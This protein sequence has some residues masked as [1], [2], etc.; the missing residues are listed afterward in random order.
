MNTN[1]YFNQLSL[2]KKRIV[3]A[4]RH[5]ANTHLNHTPRFKYFTLHGSTHIDN[6]LNLLNLLYEAGLRLDQE[7]SFYLLCAI[8]C[9]DIGMVIPLV[10][11]D[12]T[13]IFQGQEQ[14]ADPAHIEK[15]IRDTHHELVSNYLNSHSDFLAESGLSSPQCTL[16]KKIAMGHRV[17]DLSE[18]PGL[19][20]TLG[21]LLRV[22]DELDIGPSRAPT[23]I[24]RSQY[25]EWDPTSCWHWFKHNITAEWVKGHTVNIEL[26]GIPK[27]TF[28]IA[29]FPPSKTSID[30]WLHQIRRPIYK[31]LF[32]ENCHRIIQDQWGIDIAFE[33]SKQLSDI[34]QSDECWR[35]IEEK[36][37]AGQRQTILLIDDEVRK[38][39]DLM[40]PLQRDYHIIFAPTLHDAVLK[41]QATS[42]DLAIIDMQMGS[43]GIFTP[44]QTDNYKKTGAAIANM[45]RNKWPNTNI[46]ILTGSKH[47]LPDIESRNDLSFFMKKPVNP[48]T[49]E[50]EVRRVLYQQ[51]TR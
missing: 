25:H 6:L 21:A 37:L 23:T 30:Y 49:F 13:S 26:G 27:I 51:K 18:E 44:E 22:L 11:F 16:I 31:V 24:L 9:H 46:G 40:L 45:I 48:E 14:P 28:N 41:L 19:Q 15:L 10:E 39:E 2:E 36:A 12:N 20:K 17:V 4:L 35:R 34:G 32:D 43:S 50:K 7:E 5:S 1:A 47:P 3:E 8:C 33:A 29:V 38:M 42:I